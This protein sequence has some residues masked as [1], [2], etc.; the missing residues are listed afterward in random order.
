M[1]LAIC[2]AGIL[3]ALPYGFKGTAW[4][5]PQTMLAYDTE[6]KLSPDFKFVTTSLPK[7]KKISKCCNER[8]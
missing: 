3:N 8:K 6:L 4:P 1:K 7:G 5:K 2:L